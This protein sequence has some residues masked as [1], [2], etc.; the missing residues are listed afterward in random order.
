MNKFVEVRSIIELSE[1]LFLIIHE[2]KVE[3]SP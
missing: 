3:I 2:D 1:V